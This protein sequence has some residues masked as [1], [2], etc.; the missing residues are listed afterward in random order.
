MKIGP[1][2]IKEILTN[3][4]RYPKLHQSYQSIKPYIGDGLVTASVL[5]AA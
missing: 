4:A 1:E 5:F 3:T 2:A